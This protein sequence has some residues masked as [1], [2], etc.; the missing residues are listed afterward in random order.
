MGTFSVWSQTIDDNQESGSS[1]LAQKNEIMM[2]FSVGNL[3]IGAVR[4]RSQ[5]INPPVRLS[6]VSKRLMFCLGFLLGIA[7][8]A[9]SEFFPRE[10]IKTKSVWLDA[11]QLS[12]TFKEEYVLGLEQWANNPAGILLDE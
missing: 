10:K 2:L 8:P 9:K 1:D 3:N 5:N 6:A 4:S 12:L 11:L 7:A